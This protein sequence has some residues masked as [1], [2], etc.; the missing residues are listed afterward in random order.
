MYRN[1]GNQGRGNPAYTGSGSGTNSLGSNTTTTTQQE[2]KFTMAGSSQF[3]PSLNA[4]TTNQDLQWG[5]GPSGSTT[6][7]FPS[8]QTRGHQSSC[9]HYGFNK[10]QER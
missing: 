1:F 3:V 5:T 4:I 10:A 9:K 7:P 8:P 2:Q 6:S